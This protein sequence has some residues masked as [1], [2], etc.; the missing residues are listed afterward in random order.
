MQTKEISYTVEYYKDNNKV[1]EDTIIITKRVHVLDVD[2]IET[3]RTL[4]TDNDKYVGYYL[5]RTD[6]SEVPNVVDNGTIIKVYYEKTAYTYRIEYYYNGQ[7]DESLTETG[8]AYLGDVIQECPS[9]PKEGY[10]LDRTENLPLEITLTGENVIRVYYVALRKLTVEYVDKTTEEVLEQEVKVGKQGTK[11]TTEAK[12]IEGYTL[13]EKP[14][15]EEYILGEED[16]VVKYYYEKV[17]EK[18]EPT[19]PEDEKEPE[20]EPTKPED[21]PS[22]PEEKPV[23]Q[24]DPTPTE[25]QGREEEPAPKETHVIPVSQD[26]PTT[27]TTDNTMT[28]TKLPRTGYRRII[29]PLVI[30]I[31][32]AGLVFYQKYQN[33]GKKKKKK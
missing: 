7:I 33:V 24:Q 28:T 21:K 4:F 12:E 19:P 18:P 15:K 2:T 27:P 10:E 5:D 9:K 20:E 16:I 6:P 25:P 31:T 8:T 23:E 22:K 14:A 11:V 32:M 29:I 13:V 3:D 17:K 30:V 26:E 1:E